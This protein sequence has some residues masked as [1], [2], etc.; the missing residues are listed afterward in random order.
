M[1]QAGFR[2]TSRCLCGPDHVA[3]TDISL[4]FGNA[5]TS[6]PSQGVVFNR[7]WAGEHDSSVPDNHD[8]CS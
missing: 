7:G 3:N 2:K 4:D 6:F 1:G 8:Q 5:Q